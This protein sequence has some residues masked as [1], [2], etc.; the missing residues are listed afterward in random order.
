MNRSAL[1]EKDSEAEYLMFARFLDVGRRVY[2]I[3]LIAP[4]SDETR[5]EQRAARYFDSFQLVRTSQ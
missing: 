4:K 1:I 2:V 3:Q 5:L